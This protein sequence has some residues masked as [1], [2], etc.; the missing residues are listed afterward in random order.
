M[1]KSGE[2]GPFWPKGVEEDDLLR[3]VERQVHFRYEDDS[4]VAPSK[5]D[6]LIFRRSAKVNLVTG[7]VS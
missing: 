2:N 1:E 3:K 7:K 5:S 4:E 6:Y